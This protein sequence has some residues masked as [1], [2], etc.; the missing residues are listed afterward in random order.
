MEILRGESSD[1]STKAFERGWNAALDLAAYDLEHKF[2]KAFGQD[3]L[4]SIAIY[5][6]SLKHE[7][8]KP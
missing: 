6:K 5:L 2:V 1:S 4:S 8:T 7:P 3:T